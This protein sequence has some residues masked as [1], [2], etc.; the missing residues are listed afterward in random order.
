MNSG[1][2]IR[3]VIFEILLEI[4]KHNSSFEKI[5][6]TQHSLHSFSKRDKSLIY[7]VCLNAMRY[8]FHV[9]KI[10][11]KYLKKKSKKNQYILLSSAIT[12]IVFLNFKEYAV[13]NNSVEIAKKINVY[14]GLI[15]AVLKKI[16]NEKIKL[17]QTKVFF[18]DFPEW[19]KKYAENLDI[20]KINQFE[21]SFYKT[22][23]LHLVFKSEVSLK[24]FN[25][26]NVASS[27]KSVFLKEPKQIELIDDY[28][29]GNWWVQDFSSMLPL[30]L[31]TNLKNR[32]VIDLCSAPGGKAC[33]AI[34]Q[35]GDVILNDKNKKRIIVLK[36]NLKRLNFKNKI[37]N[38]DVLNF[39]I[40]KKYDFIILDA[41]CSAIGTIRRNP[42]IFYKKKAPD[43]NGLALL[44]RKLLQKASLLVNKKGVLL[45]IV[46]SF[47]YKE[48]LEQMK[49]FLSNNKN[50]SIFK[51]N[52]IEKNSEIN[53]LI[54]IKG[55]L[56]IPPTK[57]KNF[58]ID[59][60]FSVR[61][62]K[63]D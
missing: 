46:C 12:Q 9:D 18:T 54:D 38:K 60:F 50:F 19:F 47:F 58:F 40:K 4:Y 37:I 42:D 41:P 21:N 5:F 26:K 35:G 31:T 17:K 48:S 62:I 14:P 30:H 57:Y 45:Y 63:N 1:V 32:N 34:S 36:K 43:I 56:L 6:N 51:F 15:N 23:S 24:Y 20:R 11:N 53:K 49:F 33:Q 28:K 25:E 8:K 10:I 59:G 13:I 55:Y 3:F 16:C 29:K 39:S 52:K 27:T 7:N 61:F 2:K 44:Q 22:P